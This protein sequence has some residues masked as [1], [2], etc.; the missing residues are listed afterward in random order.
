MQI[1]F[2]IANKNNATAVNSNGSNR[3]SAE[4][5]TRFHSTILNIYCSNRNT[6]GFSILLLSFNQ[7]ANTLCFQHFKWN[8]AIAPFEL[9][10][11]MQAKRSNELTRMRDKFLNSYNSDDSVTVPLHPAFSAEWEKIQIQGNLIFSYRYFN[12][13]FYQKCENKMKWSIRL[14]EEIK[15]S[16]RG[17]NYKFGGWRSIVKATK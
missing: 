2:F 15:S 5:I 3:T 14:S 10:P 8:Y 4:S 6:S 13:H 1:R 7:I 9:G 16:L 17:S 11:N 12:I